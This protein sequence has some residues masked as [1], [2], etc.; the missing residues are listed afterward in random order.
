MMWVA[1][2]LRFHTDEDERRRERQYADAEELE[3]L[4][5]RVQQQAERIKHG[6]Q[7]H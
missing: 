3:R 1:R 6:A 4:A 5:E 2:L 7:G